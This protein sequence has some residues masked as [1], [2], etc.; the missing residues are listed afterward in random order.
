MKESFATC[1]NC[2]DGRLQLQIIHWIKENYAIDYV[3]MITD[4]GMDGILANKDYK[5]KDNLL[6]KI[7]ISTENHKSNHIFLIGHHNCLGNPVNDETHKKQICNAVEKLKRWKPSN[8][9]IGLWVSNKGI[10][11]KIADK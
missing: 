8:N 2:I 11:K 9:I 10:I 5:D 4:P 6:K 7:N 3:D 1:L